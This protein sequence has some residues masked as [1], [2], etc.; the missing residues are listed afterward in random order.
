MQRL[1]K[2]PCLASFIFIS[3]CALTHWSSSAQAQFVCQSTDGIGQGESATGGNLACGTGALS[4]G[5]RV[6]W[7]LRGRF[8]TK[9]SDLN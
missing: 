8:R 7:K 2:C 1:L 3:L 5:L 6:A 9:N 4:S